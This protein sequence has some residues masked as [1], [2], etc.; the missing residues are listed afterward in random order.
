MYAVF[1]QLNMTRTQTSVR[2]LEEMIDQLIPQLE[3]EAARVLRLVL[4]IR[5]IG[6]DVRPARC[7]INVEVAA[8]AVLPARMPDQPKLAVGVNEEAGGNI[9]VCSLPRYK[10][11]V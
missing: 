1:S 3:I 7:R 6:D 2:R 10:I 5:V 9:V 11:L 8:K 4:S